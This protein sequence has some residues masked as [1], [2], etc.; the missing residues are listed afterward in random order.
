MRASS[1]ARQCEALFHAMGAQPSR[2]MPQVRRASSPPFHDPTPFQEG[3]ELFRWEA[4]KYD[5]QAAACGALH[6]NED[7]LTRIAAD[8]RTNAVRCAAT[9]RAQADY[10]LDVDRGAPCLNDSAPDTA[11]CRET[12]ATELAA[13]ALALG[14]EAIACTKAEIDLR[15]RWAGACPNM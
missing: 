3:A 1:D 6:P 4:E 10:G 5:A 11:R 2:P 13:R 8:W 15:D 9:C 12:Y 7:R 14:H